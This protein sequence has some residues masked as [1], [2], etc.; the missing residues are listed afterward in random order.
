MRMKLSPTTMLAM[1]LGLNCEYLL[2]RVDGLE[3]D[4]ITHHH[5]GQDIRVKLC[6]P[7]DPR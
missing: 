2:T 7:A 6:I 4:P 1:I 3:D 5:V